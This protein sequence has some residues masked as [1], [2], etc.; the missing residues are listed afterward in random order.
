MEMNVK[1]KVMRKSRQSSPLQKPENVEYVSY[2]CSM[3]TNYA[4]CTCDIK[5]RIVSAKAA[6]NKKETFFNQVTG[7]KFKE[8]ICKVL[9]GV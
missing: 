2:L 8:A 7:P 5:S 1:K 4:R 3:M 6:F 9:H